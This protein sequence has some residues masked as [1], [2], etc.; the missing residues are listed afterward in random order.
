MMFFK[1][2][3]AFSSKKDSAIFKFFPKKLDSQQNIMMRAEKHSHEI[4]STDTH[5][6]A[7][8]PSLPILK[9]KQ[10]SSKNTNCF[11]IKPKRISAGLSKVDST[12]LEQ[13]SQK[14]VFLRKTLQVK[15]FFCTLSK[16]LSDFW[17]KVLSS[18]V[19]L[20]STYPVNIFVKIF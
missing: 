18:V 5:S 3:K 14:I 10:D 12:C 9:K 4:K 17:R 15:R 8:L 19:K 6:K 2:R 16:K 13:H 20:H 1:R 7:N 11:R